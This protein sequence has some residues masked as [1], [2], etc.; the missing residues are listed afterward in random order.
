MISRKKGNTIEIEFGEYCKVK[1]P[2]LF[3][4]D[5]GQIIKFTIN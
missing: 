4:H 2:Q 5:K 3:Q 1:A